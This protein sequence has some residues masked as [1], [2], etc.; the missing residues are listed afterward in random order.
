MFYCSL[1][2]RQNKSLAE[3]MDMTNTEVVTWAAYYNLK[4]ESH[5]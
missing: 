5:G 1:A 3:V 2:D 4:D